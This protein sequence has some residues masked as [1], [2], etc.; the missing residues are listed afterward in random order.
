MEDQWVKGWAQVFALALPQG[1]RHRP[2]LQEPRT[3][4]ENIWQPLLL[5]LSSFPGSRFRPQNPQP[6]LILRFTFQN[7]VLGFDSDVAGLT[8]GWDFIHIPPCAKAS[9]CPWPSLASRFVVP[10]T[11]PFLKAWV[12]PPST[13]R[14]SMRYSRA[15]WATLP[16]TLFVLTEKFKVKVPD[17]QGFVA[18]GKIQ[19]PR[20]FSRV[21][22]HF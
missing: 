20:A 6:W 21:T 7:T 5:G 22:F 13:C 10:A 19:P 8:G 4:P 9:P 14:S 18:V 1:G 3:D 17:K 15:H 11:H 2:D 16:A 12:Q